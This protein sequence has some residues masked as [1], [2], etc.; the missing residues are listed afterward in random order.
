MSATIQ[1]IEQVTHK[2]QTLSQERIA[3]VEDFIDFLKQRDEDLQLTRSTMKISEQLL[4]NL[5]DNADD[6]E[7]D[8]L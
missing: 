6:A 3:E 1:Q 7:Y 2:L 8:R 4:A 5:W